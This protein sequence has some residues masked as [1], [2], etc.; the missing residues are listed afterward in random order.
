MP[1]FVIR[2]IDPEAHDEVALVAERMRLTLV[3]VLGEETGGAMYTREWLE[4]RVREHLDPARLR[5]QVFVA[6]ESGGAVAGHTIVRIEEDDGGRAFGVFS[7][8]YV[9]PDARRGGVA[10]ALLDRGE[11]WMREQQV[12]VAQTWTSDT[13]DP[14]LALF[15]K[16]GYALTLRVPEKKMVVLS[17]AF[18][19]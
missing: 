12:T 4:D 2:P 18:E 10:D 8:T 19:D 7:T 16:H 5:G 13:N 15:R 11:A 9:A 3:E 17:K 1:G 6:V 14:L